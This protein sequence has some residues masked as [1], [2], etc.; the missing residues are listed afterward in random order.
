MERAVEGYSTNVQRGLFFNGGSGSAY[1]LTNWYC[2]NPNI[3][4][5]ANDQCVKFQSDPNDTSYNDQSFC[6]TRGMA[7]CRHRWR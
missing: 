2:D 1:R 5:T 4:L 7:A 6:G 3:T